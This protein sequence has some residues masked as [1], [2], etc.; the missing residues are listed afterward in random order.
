MDKAYQHQNTEK[1]IYEKWEQS[2][3]F[4]PRIDKN[5][6]PF[7]II[8]PPP[9]AN[10]PLHLG[11][12]MY[13]IE[14][15]LIRFH[16]MLG[17]SCLWLPGADH[18]GIETQFVFERLLA[19]EGK[20]RFDFKREDLF[21]MISD[22]VQKSRVIME[23]QLRALGFSLDWSRK[24]FTLD[25][26][27]IKVVYG[28]FKKLYDEGLVYRDNRL[29]NFCTRCGTGFSDYEV[30]HVTRAD[31]L[32]Y[33]K[34]GPFIIATVRPETQFG[35]TALAVNPKDKRYQQ[36]I[37][38]TIEVEGVVSKFTLKVIADDLIDPTFGSGAEKVSPG[39]D[40]KDFEL[41][42]KH[43]LEI[44]P[45]VQKDG[46]LN[47]LALAY[48]GIRVKEARLRISEDLK[49][50]GLLVKTD[51]SYVHAVPVCY[52]CGSVLE[53]ILMPQWYIKVKPLIDSAK[54]AVKKRKIVI[55]PKRFEKIYYQWLDNLHD[56]NISRQSI[57]GVSIPAW[58]CTSCESWS[59]TSGEQPQVCPK[60]KGKLVKDQD[61]FDTW[62]SS[63]QWPFAVLQNT[64]KGDFE[65]FYPTS[66]METGYDIL[67]P[68]VSRMIMLG[69]FATG[70]VPFRD[71]VL[72]GLVNDPYG[73]KMSKSKG[74]VVDPMQLIEQY[75]A[76]AVR[77]ALVYGTALGNDQV[78]SYPK[79]QAM[80]NFTNKLWNMARFIEFK[81]GENSDHKVLNM[82][83]L[84]KVIKNDVDKKMF[85]KTEKLM[86]SITKDLEVFNFNH[87]AESLYDFA[88]HEFADW[89]IEDFKKRVAGDEIIIF[90]FFLILLKLIHPFIP[91]VTE[92][93]YQRLKMGKMLAQ[94]NWPK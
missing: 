20:S 44:K 8:L 28:T 64:N 87:A 34:Y 12:A 26:D 16:R 18:A 5:Q 89:Y 81:A 2:G 43:H 55:H 46:R 38:K 19:K 11:H 33:L 24:K 82:V 22:H 42:R 59:V 25:Q 32:Y 93:I 60:C 77:F 47:S 62:F 76:D 67:K 63:A 65:Y 36:W 14:D 49:V 6:K 79:L 35:D 69:L 58:Q 15:I 90:N 13:V 68:W 74:N 3:L 73:K 39:C 78:L 30:K 45:V 75:G 80:R 72:H 83:Y 94:D 9:N 61:T 53:P 17:D 23:S 56:W 7:T 41:A 48:K 70:E 71:V 88:W 29:V 85:K 91:F 54:K 66:V 10:A 86:A 51:P 52:K 21:K 92:E 31:P 1:A 37:G 84:K 57:W 4:T 40:F 50:K 27:I